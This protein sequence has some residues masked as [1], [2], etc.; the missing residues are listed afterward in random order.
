MLCLH[1]GHDEQSL[2]PA[3]GDCGSFVG[4]VADG[5]GYLPQLKVTE[6]GLAEGV[7]T[8]AEAEK[9]LQRCSEALETM[10]HWMDECG[11]GLMTLEFD[12]LQQGT[13]GGF[14]SPLREAFETLKELVDHLDSAGDWGEETWA[15]LN[16]AQTKV[17]LGGEGMAML[18]QTLAAVAVEKG[19]DLEKVF[20][21]PEGEEAEA[22][23]E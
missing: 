10:I 15:K 11:R 1:C 21:P 19:V 7:V 23:A 9:R 2:G 5:R 16:E 14:M 6:K 22:P 17:Q 4:Y 8:P 18:T 13:L 3:C 20:A 12:D